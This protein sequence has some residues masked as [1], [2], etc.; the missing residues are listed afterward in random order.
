[1]LL[2]AL[3][4]SWEVRRINRS[5]TSQRNQWTLTD[6]DFRQQRPEDHLATAIHSLPQAREVGSDTFSFRLHP[7]FFIIF[8][9]GHPTELA[10]WQILGSETSSILL[11]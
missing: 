3:L 9:A 1:L 6:T 4:A 5:E 7:Y 10:L 8:Q 11:G 2:A